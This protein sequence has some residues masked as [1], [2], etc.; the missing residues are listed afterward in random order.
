[1]QKENNEKS[2][3]KVLPHKDLNT[4][5]GLYVHKI[6]VALNFGPDYTSLKFEDGAEIYFSNYK[7]IQVEMINERIWVSGIDPVGKINTSDDDSKLIRRFKSGAVR[8]VADG[9]P[10]PAWISPYAME[11]ISK[12]MVDNSNDFGACNYMLGIDEDACVESLCRHIGELKEAMYVLKD[13]DKLKIVARSVGFN[14]VALL[15]TLILKEKGLY[16]ERHKKTENITVSEA[17]KG[18]EFLK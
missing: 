14:V 4:L 6:G 15:H 11:E 16:V 8:S 9:R 7:L 5:Q 1:M 3:F 18:N 10:Q 12:V 13:M 17:K 2:Y